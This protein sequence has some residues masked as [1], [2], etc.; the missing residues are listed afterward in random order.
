[1]KGTCWGIAIVLVAGLAGCSAKAAPPSAGE[2]AIMPSVPVTTAPATLSAPPPEPAAAPEPLASPG[3][4]N[5]QPG[6]DVNVGQAVRRV[7]KATAVAALVV[8]HQTGTTLVAENADRPFHAGSLVKLLIGLDALR[9]HP[10]SEDVRE[11]VYNMIRVSDDPTASAFWVSEGGSAIVKRMAELIGLRATSPPD[12][13]TQ[14]GDTMISAGDVVRVYDYLMAKAP[15]SDRETILKAM[16]SSSATGSD[17]FNQRF[18][19]PSATKLQWAVKQAWT[20]NATS[21]SAHS[22]GFV[23]AEW[24]YTVVLLTEFP[25]SS[26][27]AIATQAVTAAANAVTPLLDGQ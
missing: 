2:V 5:R 4:A 8:D 7:G 27:W 9:R 1:M 10:A 12:T 3:G 18:G 23:G 11:R 20:D 26:R 25:R 13:P 6:H 22:T 21:M 16:S 17:G 19:I 15:T 14:W 24:R